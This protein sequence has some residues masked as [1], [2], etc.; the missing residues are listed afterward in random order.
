[1]NA[2]SQ[3]FEFVFYSEFFFL[4]RGDPNFVP[5]GVG[6]FV[7]YALFQFLMFFG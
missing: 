6:H 2:A 5:I 7:V 3:S 1:M 4:Q